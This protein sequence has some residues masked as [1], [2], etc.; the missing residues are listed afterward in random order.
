MNEH[1]QLIDKLEHLESVYFTKGKREEAERLRAL[2][3]MLIDACAEYEAERSIKN[4]YMLYGTM[5]L[6]GLALHGLWLDV[7]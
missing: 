2:I 1:I 5:S 7:A 4:G 3:D 6:V